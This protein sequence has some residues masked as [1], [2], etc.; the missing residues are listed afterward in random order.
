LFPEQFL[1]R[2]AQRGPQL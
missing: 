2:G 1:R